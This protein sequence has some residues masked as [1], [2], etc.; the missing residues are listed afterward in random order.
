MRSWTVL[1]HLAGADDLEPF[2]AQALLEMERA[3]PPPGVE[4]VVQ[5][6]RAP[7]PGVQGLFP[8]YRNTNIDGDWHGVRRYRLL[9]RP[10]GGNGKAYS[11]ELIAD[12]GSVSSADPG[13]LADLVVF[14]T[15]RFPAE[16]FMLVVS[17]HGMGFVG[18]A[19][20]VAAGSPG[21]MSLRGLATALRRLKRRPDLLLLDACQ[22]NCL[23]VATQLA[24]PRPA[25]SWLIAPASQAPRAGL[26]YPALLR[27]LAA[28]AEA[29]SGTVA[30]R[31]A[32]ELERRAHLQV[33][34]MD[35]SPEKWRRVV[36]T[37]RCADH[38]R[39]VP[40]FRAAA[41]ACVH[42]TA[43]KVSLLVHWPQSPH[44]PVRYHFLYRRLTFARS[45]GWHRMLPPPEEAEDREPGRGPL[46][47]PV[48]LL[49]AWLGLLRPDL[50][51]DQVD[52]L[53]AERGWKG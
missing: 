47:V 2:M 52:Q 44:F 22:M 1:F 17:G 15:E 26:D 13:L 21:L 49:A 14:A 32:A 40:M 41:D 24:L 31:V 38:A 36:E 51:R 46:R 33:L 8:A 43:G 23:E 53:L 34:A 12:L 48:P 27:A 9:A 7:A 6:A 42:P 28:G 20:D 29:P 10:D 30:A 39:Y 37:A 45:S 11:S 3:G 25:V 4:V 18:L 35:L 19:L 50:T 16:R 5:I